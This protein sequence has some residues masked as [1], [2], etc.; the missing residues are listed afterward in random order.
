MRL[1]VRTPELPESPHSSDKTNEF[2]QLANLPVASASSPIHN[3]N[4]GK[5]KSMSKVLLAGVL[6]LVVLFGIGCATKGYVRN[7]VEPVINKVN[8]LDQRTAE[9]TTQI[10]ATD[11]RV[12]QG[13]ETLN[14]STE[15]ANRR[16]T[17]ADTK[18]Q[19]AQQ[20]ASAANTN[21][22]SLGETVAKLDTYH[23]VSQVAVQFGFADS[24]LKPAAKQA[25][26]EFSGK[27]SSAKNYLVVVE[28][29]TDASGSENYNNDLSDRRAAQ[30]VR[31]LVSKHHV[32]LF[33][34]HAIGL[35]KE[36]PAA[37]NTSASGRRQ[38][39]R[40]DIK[41]MSNLG[42]AQPQGSTSTGSDD[43]DEV[44]KA[45]P[46]QRCTVPDR[47]AEN[48]GNPPENWAHLKSDRPWF[49]M[50]GQSPA[51]LNLSAT[52]G[53]WSSTRTPALPSNNVR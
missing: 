5:G 46:N 28:G 40:A 49:R 39:R 24:R 27:L 18:A 9:N 41:L 33:K 21:V 35:G 16:A 22:N 8:E 6:L 29:R 38:N 11:A 51:V 3:I 48:A 34:V 1:S 52:V 19:Q 10:K 44:A 43:D 42:A 2:L 13:L 32:P 7:Q 31:Y 4:A 20:S 17:D 30:V 23:V 26:D 25:L 50:D 47:Q 53:M 14:T 45:V 12:Q 36:R 15:Q 37:P